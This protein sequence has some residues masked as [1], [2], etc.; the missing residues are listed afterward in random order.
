MSS[1]EL[2][3]YPLVE[4]YGYLID[5]A[6][7]NVLEELGQQI[8]ELQSDFSKGEKANYTLAGEIKHEYN[9]KPQFQTKQYIKDLAQRFENKS[10]YMSS[11]YNPIPTLK[12]ENLWVNFQKK[13]EYNPIHNHTGVYSFVI[14]YQIPFTFE[15]EKKYKHTPDNKRCIHGEF[16]FVTPS[17]NNINEVKTYPLGIDHSKEGYIAI[18]PSSLGHMVNPFYSSEGYRITVAGNIKPHDALH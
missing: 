3:Y 4:N 11:N 9:I 15:N 17:F 10:Q 8:N 16:M 6:P 18:F 5:K 2:G 14:W 12:F 1:L 13:H 7:Q